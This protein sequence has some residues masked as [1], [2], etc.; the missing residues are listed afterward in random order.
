MRRP[1][2]TVIPPL[3]PALPTTPTTTSPATSN[4]WRRENG[5][6]LP[7]SKLAVAAAQRW[8]QRSRGSA[9]LNRSCQHCF[10]SRPASGVNGWNDVW[11]SFDDES[12]VT[13]ELRV[14]EAGAQESRPLTDP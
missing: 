5:G 3:P 13:N 4:S 2:A 11:L 8:N 7:G 9:R 10:F 12:E 1:A 6:L 14:H